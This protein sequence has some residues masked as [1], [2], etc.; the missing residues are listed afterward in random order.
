MAI[1]A[2]KAAATPISASDADVLDRI[3]AARP[4][5]WWNRFWHGAREAMRLVSREEFDR[6]CVEVHR[7][8]DGQTMYPDDA[9]A[10]AAKLI[11]AHTGAEAAAAVAKCQKTD[12]AV[13]VIRLGPPRAGF[14]FE[15]A[16]TLKDPKGAR[17]G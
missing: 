8:L 1:S 17:R 16:M 5:R 14:L 13:L 10:K 4:K 9:A 3:V 12:T 6:A 11:N 7:S 2:A 15:R